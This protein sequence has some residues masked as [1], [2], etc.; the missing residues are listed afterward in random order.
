MYKNNTLTLFTVMFLAIFL[1]QPCLGKTGSP[2]SGNLKQNKA[3]LF[4]IN[5][6]MPHLTKLI[7][8]QWNNPQ[9]ELTEKQKN[10]LLA[11]RKETMAAV[12]II[13]GQVPDLENQ[14][15]SAIMSGASP[16]SLHP[17]VTQISALKEKAT[18]IHLNCIYKTRKILSDKQ[19][20]LLK[21]SA[22]K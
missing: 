11:L 19:I 10:Q 12:K 2:A 20:A 7:K 13:G 17:L 3:T 4:L 15:A 21:K 1:V 6:K 8:Q 14:V 5:G 18:M 22:G 9:L 16:D